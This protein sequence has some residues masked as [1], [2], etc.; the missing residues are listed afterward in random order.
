MFRYILFR[1]PSGVHHLLAGGADKCKP[2]LGSK[3]AGGEAGEG[4]RPVLVCGGG[5]EAGNLPGKRTCYWLPG[6]CG[7]PVYVL[8]SCSL[9]GNG[10]ILFLL[11]L[12][13]GQRVTAC[14]TVWGEEIG[15]EMVTFF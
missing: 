6:V 15:R 13:E 11:R 10:V 2:V 14:T 1:T 3:Q 4:S 9:H 5:G 7:A 8:I 12:R